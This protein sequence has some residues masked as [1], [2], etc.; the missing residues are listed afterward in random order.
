MVRRGES[1][2]AVL[3]TSPVDIVL[4]A[5]GP[6]RDASQM[7]YFQ[8]VNGAT[9]HLLSIF[10]D[11]HLDYNDGPNDEPGP[12]RPEWD[13]YLGKCETRRWGKLEYKI[14]IHR[15]NGYLYGA[16]IRFVGEFKPGMFATSDGET[17]DFTAVIPTWRS[18]PLFK[19][20]LNALGVAS[21]RA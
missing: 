6:G 10:G 21:V 1:E 12:N 18:V 7:K 19:A 17:V 14:S 8:G 13:K 3:V 20:S 4:P 15:K 11:G 2:V 5:E 9:P 16:D